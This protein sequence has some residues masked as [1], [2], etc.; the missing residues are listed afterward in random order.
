[1]RP[2]PLPRQGQLTRKRIPHP[3]PQ[4]LPLSSWR[5]HR[6]ADVLE[7]RRLLSAAPPPVA[8]VAEGTW[9]VLGGRGS[10]QIVVDVS[11]DDA[12]TLR[13]AIGGKV[14][15]T[16]P[17]SSVKR[18][19][20]L[21]GPGN[22]EVTIS[23]GGGAAAIDVHVDGGRGRDRIAGGDGDE[24]LIGGLGADVISGG[25]GDDRLAGGP[26]NDDLTGGEGADRLSGG[27]GRDRLH[28]QGG[29][30]LTS[31]DRRDVVGADGSA[32]TLKRLPT[33]ESVRQWLVEAAVRQYAWSFD[34]PAWGWGWRAGTDGT[35]FTAPMPLDSGA[36]GAPSQS[37]TAAGG[38]VGDGF[39]QTNVQSAGVDEADLVETDGRY[40]Y[41]LR[42]APYETVPAPNP[43]G[44]TY[45]SPAPPQTQLVIADA[46]R[47][48]A[49]SVAARVTVDGTPTGM[50]L[51]GGRLAVVTQSYPS[52]AWLDAGFGGVRA[53]VRF[54]GGIAG[55]SIIDPGDPKVTVTVFDVSDPAAPKVVE[56]TSL[57]GSYDT[58]RAI[59]DRVYV[60]VRNDTWVP[61]PK[62]VDGP[63]GTSVYESEASYRQRLGATPLA[64]LLPQYSA[65]VAGGAATA[66]ALVAAPDVYVKE[67]GAAEFGQNMETVAVL[68]VGDDAA[69][70]SGTT[71]IAGWAGTSYASADSLY[72]ASPFWEAGDS[73]TDTG[74]S[75]TN[76]FKFDLDPDAV[77]LVATGEVEGSV[78]N[79]FSMDEQ[80]DD[81]RV[82][83]T[84]TEPAV[85]SDDLP[86]PPPP[87]TSNGVYVLRQDGDALKVVGSVTKLGL[88][89]R[90]Q[91]ARFVGNMA[92]LVTFR[93]TDP[94][95]AI[96]LSDPIHPKV[97]GELQIPGF[98][99]YLQPLGDGLL[100]GVGRDADETGRAKGIQLSLFD[101]SDPAKPVRLAAQS[102]DDEGPWGWSDAEHNHLAVSY[103]PE[104]HVLA[105]P[106]YRFS[107]AWTG[108]G[109]GTGDPGQ[110]K[111]FSLEVFRVGREEGIEKLGAIAA[112]SVI[113]RSLRIGTAVFAVGTDEI[114]AA[115]VDAPGTLLGTLSLRGTD[116]PGPG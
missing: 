41:T 86:P 32:A 101:V 111:P 7:V 89:E 108:S 56:E 55:S 85:H 8:P 103:F 10:D 64:E 83:T 62:T 100:L 28:R 4:R 3:V 13:A 74:H 73:D 54:T 36:G 1:M 58:S 114:Q 116:E 25:G 47:A 42:S 11:P 95:F 107:Y 69:G 5:H 29:V 46:A 6:T 16:R 51:V 53:P 48:D 24:E 40:I 39:S 70:P 76:L 115:P 14:V 99:T 68:N 113:S 98:S 21:G 65:K 72:L 96:N 57:D 66:G 80:G 94:L 87:A 63:D 82:A 109:A 44:S 112:D 75:G 31:R 37:L 97:A 23:L 18:I 52:Y 33:D 38:A 9:Q 92:Y 81:L 15:A 34:K 59:G 91:S 79:Q 12:A 78:L 84:A 77:P 110:P 71:T 2:S 30:D 45:L 106:L 22:D 43:D 104:Q 93:R 27:R 49:M 19:D 20:V 60:V 50:Y 26:G 102:L 61:A 88:T 90:I 105:I 17:A 67:T 35:V